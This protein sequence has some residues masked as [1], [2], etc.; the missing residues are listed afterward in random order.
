MHCLGPPGTHVRAGGRKQTYFYIMKMRPTCASRHFVDCRFLHPPAHLRPEKV[1]GKC[2][3]G[4]QKAGHQRQ[5]S[6]TA[7]SRERPHSL[8]GSWRVLWAP[9]IPGVGPSLQ[10]PQSGHHFLGGPLSPARFLDGCLRCSKTL[11]A[12]PLAVPAH[13]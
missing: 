11:L 10:G 9:F 13:P 6:T 2:W 4:R 3:C 5:L 7:P 1:C 12:V 8:S